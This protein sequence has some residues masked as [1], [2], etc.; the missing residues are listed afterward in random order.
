V[1]SFAAQLKQIWQQPDYEKATFYANSI[2]D[3]F[4]NAYPQAISTLEDGL[5]D[6][7][8]YYNFP[9][10]DPRKISSTN[11]LERLFREIRR[12]TKVAGIFPSM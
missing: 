6:T 3:E 10:I 2:I 9:E 12:R 11:I 5:E 7:L 1:D 4:Q 8:Q